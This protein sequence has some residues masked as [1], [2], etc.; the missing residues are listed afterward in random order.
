MAAIC[1]AIDNLDEGKKMVRY[2]LKYGADINKKD[3][4][5]R[6]AFLMAC[7]WNLLDIIDIL[8]PYNPDI[9]AATDKNVE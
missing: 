9:N 5:G 6:T 1:N 7:H 8:V 3:Q 2:L 4:A